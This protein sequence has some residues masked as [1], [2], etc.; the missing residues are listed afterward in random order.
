ME[1]KIIYYYFVVAGSS[2]FRKRKRQRSS[3]LFLLPVGGPDQHTHTHTH[4]TYSRTK[5]YQEH[6]LRG[7]R[8]VA[9]HLVTPYVMVSM[10]AM[11]L[12]DKLCMCCVPHCA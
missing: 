7:A 6:I 4:S 8:T 5:H 10:L 1:K 9:K 3:F 2:G 11:C 12:A